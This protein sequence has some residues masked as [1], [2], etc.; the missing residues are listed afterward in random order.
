M[1]LRNRVE[2]I[3]RRAGAADKDPA[4]MTPAELCTAVVAA[5]EGEQDRLH[6]LPAHL[7]DDMLQRQL[8]GVQRAIKTA[9]G[10]G[11]HGPDLVALLQVC[12]EGVGT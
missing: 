4:E 5:L 12:A 10:A 6:R 11:L 7:P 8:E 3:E 2:T 1:T 9:Q